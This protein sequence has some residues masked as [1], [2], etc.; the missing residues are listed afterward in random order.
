MST[1]AKTGAVFGTVLAL[2]WLVLGFWPFVFVAAA[3]AV[4]VVVGR[5]MDGKL[6]VSNLVDVFRGQRSSS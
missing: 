6:S 1:S 2:T 3:M 5:I 4:G